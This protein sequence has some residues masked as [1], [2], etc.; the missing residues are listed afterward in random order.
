MYVNEACSLKI[1]S[2]SYEWQSLAVFLG[3]VGLCVY[4]CVCCSS[5][6]FFQILEA[7]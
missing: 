3:F 2:G 4:V 5:C 7:K 1:S 6:L